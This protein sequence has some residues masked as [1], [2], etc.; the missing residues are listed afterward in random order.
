MVMRNYPDRVVTKKLLEDGRCAMLES[1]ELQSDMA[2]LGLVPE[3]L[4]Y[5]SAGFPAKLDGVGIRLGE[6]VSSQVWDL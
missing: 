4:A 6:W 1:D 2:V 5:L 3:L